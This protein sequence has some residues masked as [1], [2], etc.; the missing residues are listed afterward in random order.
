MIPELA[1]GQPAI[2]AEQQGHGHPPLHGAPVT[3]ETMRR[4]ALRVLGA[5]PVAKAHAAGFSASCMPGW[6]R[7]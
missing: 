7:L 1:R 3:L 2:G 4:D 5:L 6:S